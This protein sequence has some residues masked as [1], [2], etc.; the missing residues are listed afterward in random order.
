[1]VSF[2]NSSS[3]ADARLAKRSQLGLTRRRDVPNRTGYN[4]DIAKLLRVSLGCEE[5]CFVGLN[6]SFPIFTSPK[7]GASSPHITYVPGFFCIAIAPAILLGS[8]GLLGAP[9]VLGSQSPDGWR[10]SSSD[11]VDNEESHRVLPGGPPG[12]PG[13]IPQQNHLISIVV[14]HLQLVN[15]VKLRAN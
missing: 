13:F 6:S 7:P 4:L 5:S 11:S 12:I 10:D 2:P 9:L 1:M 14:F 8:S 3:V 15:H